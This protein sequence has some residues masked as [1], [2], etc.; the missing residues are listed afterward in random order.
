MRGS[1]AWVYPLHMHTEAI[2]VL[3]LTP[4]PYA[5]ESQ[6]T[7]ARQESLQNVVADNIPNGSLCMV[8]NTALSH[9]VALFYL[10]KASVVAS[11]GEVS[12]ATASGVGRWLRL[13]PPYVP[14]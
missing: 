3:L 5:L 6:T 12:I 1:E 2:Q 4:R 14:N 8:M 9:S 10:D 7:G 13:A 11:D